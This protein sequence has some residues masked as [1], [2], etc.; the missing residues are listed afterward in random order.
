MT[1][2]TEDIWNASNLRE[3]KKLLQELKKEIVRIREWHDHWQTSEE[4]KNRIAKGDIY[5]Y[6]G[7]DFRPKLKN[8]I[9]KNKLYS[10]EYKLKDA[11]RGAEIERD[12]LWA[13]R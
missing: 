8:F 6:P 7:S 3:S 2:N 1:T 4:F 9:Y 5:V 11:L 12:L 10:A 13:N